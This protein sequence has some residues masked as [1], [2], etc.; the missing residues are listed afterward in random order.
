MPKKKNSNGGHKVPI[1]ILTS[2]NN[3]NN[4]LLDFSNY[5]TKLQVNY[6]NP[7]QIAFVD[8]S[9]GLKASDFVDNNSSKLTI[10]DGTNSVFANL[11]DGIVD[12]SGLNNTTV[13]SWDFTYQC[14]TFLRYEKQVTASYARLFST[15]VGDSFVVGEAEANQCNLT[16]VCKAEFSMEFDDYGISSAKFDISDLSSGFAVGDSLNDVASIL[17]VSNGTLEASGTIDDGFVDVTLLAQYVQDNNGDNALWSLT[18]SAVSNNGCS[19]L[20]SKDIVLD[21]QDSIYIID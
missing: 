16:V 6:L 8:V 7:T 3:N 17:V 5:K 20:T 12:V 2:S 11:S 21:G 18:Y 19:G 15:T 14:Y 4:V 9:T 13:Q 1:S 10:S